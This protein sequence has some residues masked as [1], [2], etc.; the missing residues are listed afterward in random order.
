MRRD[1]P[2]SPAQSGHPLHGTAEQPMVNDSPLDDEAV[3]GDAETEMID[4]PPF[5][6]PKE[7]P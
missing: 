5:R 6:A 7:Y 1:A 4:A 3:D 2:V